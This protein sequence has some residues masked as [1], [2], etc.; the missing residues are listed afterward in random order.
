MEW[1]VGRFFDGTRSRML[2]FQGRWERNIWDSCIYILSSKDFCTDLNRLPV[3]LSSA[4]IIECYFFNYFFL[5]FFFFT[6]SFFHERRFLYCA[7]S[8]VP[9]LLNPAP[10]YNFSSLSS[11]KKSP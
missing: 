6:K 1:M 2:M 11:S 7:L 10:V 3:V 4:L 8:Y 9:N 5:D